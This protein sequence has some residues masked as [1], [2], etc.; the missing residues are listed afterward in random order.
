MCVILLPAVNDSQKDFDIEDVF[1][2]NIYAKAFQNVQ[3]RFLNLT[4]EQVQDALQKGKG[5]VNNKASSLL[6]KSKTKYKLDKIQIAYEILRLISQEKELD[7]VLIKNF[8]KL[9]DEL[10]KI[11]GLYER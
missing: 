9:F 8:D 6:K 7:D 11:I 3:G 2:L 10:H 1:P 4:S 5:K